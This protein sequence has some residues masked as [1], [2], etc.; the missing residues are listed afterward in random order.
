MNACLQLKQ[1][2]D[3]ETQKAQ[4]IVQYEFEELE[5]LKHINHTSEKK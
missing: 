2:K 4:E 3:Y 1:S 5:K